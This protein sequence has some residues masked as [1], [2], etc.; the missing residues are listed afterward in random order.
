MAQVWRGPLLRASFT[1]L[2]ND[3]K[4]HSCWCTQEGSIAELIA[5]DHPYPQ[6][7]YGD[8]RVGW[9]AENE[10][11]GSGC[12]LDLA[13]SSHTS[14]CASWWLGLLYAAPQAGQ[15]QAKRVLQG[16]PQSSRGW[17]SIEHMPF[18]TPFIP[19]HWWKDTGFWRFWDY[20][21]CPAE[22][23]YRPIDHQ[24][25][26]PLASPVASPALASAV[27]NRLWH[28]PVASPVAS[29]GGIAVDIVHR[30]LYNLFWHILGHFCGIL[31][32]I[33]LRDPPVASR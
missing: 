7:T 5:G 16:D 26:R 11:P 9:I 10:D 29:A 14:V 22:I 15:G 24:W 2:R 6:S 19:D 23:N 12:S 18:H 3:P 20:R 1:W 32:G 31:V 4:A 28:R 21:V 30:I 13:S 8:S 27:G 33:T 25:H 17:C